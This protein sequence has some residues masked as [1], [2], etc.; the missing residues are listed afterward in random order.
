[1]STGG[2]RLAINGAATAVLVRHLDPDLMAQVRAVSDGA[3][4]F[5][6]FTV[7]TDRLRPLVIDAQD[8]GEDRLLAQRR[9]LRL[10]LM[11]GLESR[12]RWSSRVDRVEQLEGRAVVHLSTGERIVAD[13]VVGAE[14]ANSPT[15]RC[16][17]TARL[18]DD[19]RLTGIAGSTPRTVGAPVPR[20]LRRGP[21]LVFSADGTGMFLSLTSR[22]SGPVSPALAAAVGPPSLVWGLIA[23]AHRVDGAG[24]MT[25]DL[26]VETAMRLTHRWHPWVQSQIARTNRDR[27]AAYG[28]R[29]AHPDSD[30]TPWDPRHVTA[31][32]DAIHAMPP[33][34][35]RAA[36][37][38]LL[39]AGELADQIGR[40]LNGDVPLDE[41]LRRYHHNLREWAVPALKE[42][43]GPVSLIH[44]LGN[45]AA[46]VVARPLLHV[47][48][49][50]GAGLVGTRAR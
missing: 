17:T 16:V 1:M 36:A 7:A 22:G 3:D 48:G 45:P 49:L 5:A 6:H 11:S 26:L 2:Y 9:A 15:V 47:A 24:E 33:T 25:A 40:H 43:L 39:D 37:T 4:Q 12:M 10:L 50:I 44:L 23:P 29:A 27:V 32:G 28:F 13:L 46:S 42:S 34:G 30:L 38:A 18:S 8:A 31:L 14:G 41:A 20:F 21:A 35:G 19:L